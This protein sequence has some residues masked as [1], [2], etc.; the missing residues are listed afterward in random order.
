M[1]QLVF[2]RAIGRHR[3]WALTGV[4]A[5]CVT[6]AATL[7]MF[8]LA[9]WFVAEASRTGASRT[10]V[11]GTEV[12]GI[13]LAENQDLA[14]VFSALSLTIII[15]NPGLMIRVLA[16]IRMVGRYIERIATH[17]AT[18]GVLADLRLWLFRKL[19]PLAPAR[20]GTE[21][22]GDL[23]A[24]AVGDVDT[25]D[26][27]YIRVLLPTM[28]AL[29]VSAAALWMLHDVRPSTVSFIALCLLLCGVVIP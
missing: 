7:G 10:E 12:G 25:L 11:G 24:R 20:V 23:L 22:S 26:G 6:A 28:V 4:L 2:L 5:S 19:L 15:S 29:L 8:A 18:F 17:E 3:W 13:D 16:V 27:L 14:L 1:K 9:G 21:R